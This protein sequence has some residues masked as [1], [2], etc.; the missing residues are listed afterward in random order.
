MALL[1]VEEALRRLLADAA[2][3]E[4]ETIDP[5]AANGRVLAAPLAA[6]LTQ[7]P[8]DASAMDGYAVRA[9][10]V[11]TVP[12]RLAVKGEAAAGRGFAG[13]VGSGEAVRIFTGAPVPAGADA[14]VIQENC[15]RDGDIVIV[16]EGTADH[17][18]VRARGIDFRA[19]DRLLAAGT[20]LGPRQI[21]LAAAMGHGRLPVHRRPVVAILASGDELVL[22]GEPP[23]AD[24]IV[25]SNPYGVAAMVL[26]AGGEP[27]FLGIARDNRASIER[28][29]A[30]AAGADILI[31]IGG[32]SVGDHDLIAPVLQANG[33]ALDFWK[34]AM[35]PGKPMMYGRLGATRML[36]L[37]GNPVSSLICAR[38]FMVPL[39][40]RLAGRGD[41]PARAVEAV[42]AVDLEANGPRAHYMRATLSASASGPPSVAPVRSQDS[43]L[44][45][46]LAGADC[47]L[48]RPVGAA[49]VKA[50][51]IVPVL[52][53]DF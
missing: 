35:R 38:V 45:S 37:P 5:L 1:A 21:T 32:A 15:D 9:R 36:G 33:L 34:I 10:D 46:P 22:P 18:H 31:T 25:C 53:L 51:G 43:S 47:L 17:S 30:A 8:F 28:H 16:R 49:A 2:P 29:L 4:T 11:A 6:T 14:I 52:P 20:R 44:L 26:G 42:A 48:V 24:Q 40:E 13:V 12:V 23:Q 39:I 41:D 19:G 7:P 27:R 50:G 3:L